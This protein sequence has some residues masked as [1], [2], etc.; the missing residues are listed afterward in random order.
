MGARR[1]LRKIGIW[2][3]PNWEVSD[4]HDCD[5]DSARLEECVD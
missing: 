1:V 3:F 5:S 4:T 2:K